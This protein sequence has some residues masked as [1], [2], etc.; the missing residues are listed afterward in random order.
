[1]MTLTTII[2]TDG[3]AP[4]ILARTLRSLAQCARPQQH[5]ETI[6]VENGPAQRARAIIQE[7]LP[8]IAGRYLYH[9]VGN[10]SAALNAALRHTE[11]EVIVFFDDDVRLSRDV[12]KIY[13]SAAER[14]SGRFWGGP[15]GVDYDHAPPDWLMGYLPRSAKG[16]TLSATETDQIDR[17]T[18]LGF[19]WAAR[20]TDLRRA[21]GFDEN[22]GPGAPTGATGQE[23][24]MQQRLISDGL[25]GAYLADAMVWHYVPQSRCSQEWLIDRAFRHGVEMA[26]S[27]APAAAVTTRLKRRMFLRPAQ[28]LVASFTRDPRHEFRAAF[29]ASRD[30]GIAHGLKLKMAQPYYRD[31]ARLA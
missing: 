26:L 7:H 15:T 28:R 31:R 17:P 29:S 2:P 4:E 3:S 19:N 1:M 16:F 21:G 27:D 23:S 24:S 12:L 11:S 14:L 18:F 13:A 25:R 5:V 30:R 20:A 6:V 9:P 8:M 22:R 10:K